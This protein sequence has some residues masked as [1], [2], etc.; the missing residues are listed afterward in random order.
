MD[1]WKEIFAAIS[2]NMPNE[3]NAEIAEYV[4]LM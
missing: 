1:V 3:N 4:L 2:Y